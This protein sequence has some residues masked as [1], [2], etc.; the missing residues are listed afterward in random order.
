MQTGDSSAVGK[1]QALNVYYLVG[2]ERVRHLYLSAG[3]M[4][5]CS[6]FCDYC[7]MWRQVAVRRRAMG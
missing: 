3:N 7:T 5:V 4:N 1:T 2:K 6:E